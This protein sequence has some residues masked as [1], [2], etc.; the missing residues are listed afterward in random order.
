M[1]CKL[2][3]LLKI[4]SVYALV[5]FKTLEINICRSEENRFYVMEGKTIEQCVD[6]CRARKHCESLNYRTKINLCELFSTTNPDN[7]SHG[8]CIYADKRNLQPFQNHCKYGE[9]QET[10]GCVIKECVNMT[11]PENGM[12]LG[13]MMT[14]GAKIRYICE[15][16]YKLKDNRYTSVAECL[17]TGHWSDNAECVLVPTI[18]RHCTRDTDCV[19]TNGTCI[20]RKCFCNHLYRYNE[21]LQNCIKVCDS[22]TDEFEEFPDF[23]INSY[24]HLLYW[25]TLDSTE[26]LLTARVPVPEP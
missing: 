16:G 6:E 20:R 13:N 2:F 22:M 21:T 3:V 17:N 18:G 19:E 26:I 5:D 14:V 7:L 24:S 23:A 8:D 25:A 10:T 15:N 9:V 1:K 4:A 11:I 12:V